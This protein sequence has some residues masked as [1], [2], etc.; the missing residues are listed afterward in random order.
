MR[1]KGC[2]V[3]PTSQNTS[4][5]ASSSMASALP[6][7]QAM[8]S[9]ASRMARDALARTTMR[10]SGKRI[11]CSAGAGVSSHWNQSGASRPAL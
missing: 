6:T 8:S 2:T 5:L 1:G 4:A 11:D 10:P 3:R 9:Q 7:S